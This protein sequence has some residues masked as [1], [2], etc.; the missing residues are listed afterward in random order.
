MGL[1]G[2]PPDEL[3]VREVEVLA[4]VARYG[5]RGAAEHLFLSEHTI[6]SYLN[7]AYARLDAHTLTEALLKVGWLHVPEGL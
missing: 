5:R 7:R 3:T 4:G 1:R 2:V 6:K